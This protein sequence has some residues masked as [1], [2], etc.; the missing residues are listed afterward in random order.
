MSTRSVVG[1]GTPDDFKGR[2]VH[3]DGYLDYMKPTLMAIFDQRGVEAGLEEIMSCTWSSLD[4]DVQAD[5]P[6]GESYCDRGEAE[7][8]NEWITDMN[9]RN[10]GV[11]YAYLVTKEQNLECW[12]II[13]NNPDLKLLA[14]INLNGGD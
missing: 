8:R 2:Y 14:S 7:A 1:I 9:F 4:I 3:F 5:G 12:Q 11:E 13:W 6:I 10:W